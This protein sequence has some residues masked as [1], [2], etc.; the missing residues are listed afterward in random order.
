MCLSC[1]GS[2]HRAPSCA[3]SLPIMGQNHHNQR[4]WRGKVF[5]PSV[6]AP[7][8]IIHIVSVLLDTCYIALGL[9]MLPELGG[10]K[11]VALWHLPPTCSWWM[12]YLSVVFSP[13]W[14]QTRFQHFLNIALQASTT[15][16]PTEWQWHVTQSLSF[17]LILTLDFLKGRTMSSASL[18][19]T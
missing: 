12:L 2:L 9:F 3:S 18:H 4:S 13:H 10:G 6:E 5:P 16:Q 19:P 7:P 11:Y 14:H 8:R 1:E 15:N 17:I